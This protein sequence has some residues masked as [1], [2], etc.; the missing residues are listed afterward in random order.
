MPL[1]TC[2]PGACPDEGGDLKANF[3]DPRRTPE[4][5]QWQDTVG[6]TAGPGSNLTR[7]AANP[8]MA[9][10]AGAVSTQWFTRGDG[11]VEFGAGSN[12]TLH[13]LGLSIVPAPCVFPCTDAS[14]DYATI[15][16]A[17]VLGS[18]GNIYVYLAGAFV[19]GPLLNGSF[20]SY[21]AT[22]R[23][24]VSWTNNPQLD[25]TASVT[26]GRVVLPPCTVGMPCSVT[27]LFTAAPPA[28]YPLR[29]DTSFLEPGSTL[30]DVRV[31]YI[32]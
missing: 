2:F 21:T 9:Y 16:Y 31:V 13:V 28:S 12:T 1:D 6:T 11:Y 4:P 22:D 30:T 14:Q 29:V 5:V 23:L 7:T 17:F 25:G 8:T 18:E 26:F 24:R 27:P 32:K 10:D 19:K 15:D 3:V 20:G